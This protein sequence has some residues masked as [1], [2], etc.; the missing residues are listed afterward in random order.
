MRNGLAEGFTGMV[1]QLQAPSE[2]ATLPKSSVTPLTP[3]VCDRFLN[4]SVSLK[5]EHCRVVEERE[6]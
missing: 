5:M 6:D 2:Y 1:Q 4:E 3:I